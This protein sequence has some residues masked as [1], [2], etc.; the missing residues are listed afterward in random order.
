[1]SPESTMEALYQI[2]T[3]AGLDGNANA[4][5]T[6]SGAAGALATQ[7]TPGVSG[8]IPKFSTNV[9]PASGTLGGVGWRAGALHLVLLAGDI[10]PVAAFTGVTAPTSITGAG[11]SSEPFTAFENI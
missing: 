5:T 11:G 7:T 1:D 10:A 6:D 9:L 2:A 8:D 4:N 3:G